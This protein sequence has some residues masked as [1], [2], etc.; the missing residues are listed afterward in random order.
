MQIRLEHL[1]SQVQKP[2]ITI[3]MSPQMQQAIQLLQLPILELS[4]KIENELS[5][6]PVLEE[7]AREE[8]GEE[9][10][11]ETPGPNADEGQQSE[12]DLEFKAEFDADGAR[13]RRRGAGSA[14]RPGDRQH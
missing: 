1:Q 6:N 7:I 8:S 2:I 4:Q 11:Q 10:A 3:M 9:Q 5:Q 12:K 13:R 14:R